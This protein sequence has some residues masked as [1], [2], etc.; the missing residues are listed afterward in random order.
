MHPQMRTAAVGEAAASPQGPS[1]FKHQA[2]MAVT[3]VR[4]GWQEQVHPNIL[5][6]TEVTKPLLHAIPP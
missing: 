5:L 3:F 2:T 4:L 6:T 1:E